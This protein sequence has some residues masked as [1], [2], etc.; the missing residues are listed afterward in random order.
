MLDRPIPHSLQRLPVSCA[1]HATLQAVEETP[2]TQFVDLE[3][4]S[5]S[6]HGSISLI[7]IYEIQRH[8]VF[9]VDVHVLGPKAFSISSN[10]GICLRVLLGSSTAIE[11]FFDVRNDADALYC[12]F[13]IRLARVRD[14][15]LLE[16]ATRLGHRGRLKV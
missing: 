8:A 15:Q 9:L 12:L 16:L 1:V 3:G 10:S 4:V 13:G 7:Q 6:R 5:L 11:Y 14:T 2:L